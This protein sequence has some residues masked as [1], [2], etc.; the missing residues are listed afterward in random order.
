MNK[1]RRRPMPPH[2][3]ASSRIPRSGFTLIEM[4]I[5]V[6]LVLLMM[7]L[8]AE[9]FGL[10]SESM[11]LQQAIADGDQQV[12]SFTTVFRSDIQKRTFQTLVP[13]DNSEDPELAGVPFSDRQGYLYI[14]LNDPDNSTD[15]VLQFTVRSTIVDEN[16]D[17]T[18]YFG[19]ASGLV[20]RTPNVGSTSDSVQANPQQPEHDDGDLSNNFT[21]SSSAAEIA[22]FMRGGRLYRRVVLVREPLNA[23]GT[24]SGQPRLTWDTDGSVPFATPHEFLRHNP[25]PNTA[26]VIQTNNTGEYLKY[27]PTAGA[28]NSDDYWLDF[29]HGAYQAIA[30]T[31]PLSGT[32]SID[33]AQ[34]VDVSLLDNAQ[35]G[36]G[37][38]ALGLKLTP[39]FKT[40]PMGILPPTF[41][42]VPGCV[43]FGFDQTTGI[44]REF[45]HADPSTAGFSFLGRYTLE[46]MSHV[47][48][49]FPQN[50]A[51]DSSGTVIGNPMSYAN[52]PAAV[53]AGLFPDGVVDEFSGGS[54]RGQDLLLSNVHEF[55]I[56]IWDDSIGAF[57]SLGHQQSWSED[58]NNNGTLDPGEDLNGNNSIDTFPGD[59]HRFRNNQLVAGLVDV[60][61]SSAAWSVGQF[62]RWAGRS[63]DTWHRYSD[64]DGDFTTTADRVPPPYRAMTF[65][66]PG[67]PKGPYVSRGAWQTSTGGSPTTYASGDIVFPTGTSNSNFVAS[68]PRDYSFYY[69]C[70]DGGTSLLTEDV[71]GNNML[72]TEDANGNGVLDGDSTPGNGLFTEDV[73]DNGALDF[74]D[75]NGNFLIDTGEPVWPA[76]N[77][78][79]VE[80]SVP[81]NIEPR[82]VARRN[83][84][85][86]RAIR[87]RVRFFHESSGRM[88]QVSLVHS[89]VD[90]DRF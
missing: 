46:E 29:D 81:G 11:T 53:D 37:T 22:Y 52:F 27:D 67:S 90:E 83:V 75:T 89:L 41:Y 32:F 50:P 17:D 86:L 63:F 31:P 47:R 56:D 71:N 7:V 58:R 76:I 6:A 12:R 13:F 23:S 65:Y 54:R 2:N 74:E 1:R 33:G 68:T 78:A 34:L 39:T 49:N 88:R 35:N 24:N 30:E 80:R 36:G 57:T 25:N 38:Q 87:I 77:R 55:E 73:N 21:A 10:A 9:I 14:Q 5:S 60:P 40:D 28:L 66:P 61:G 8:F 82:W 84:K 45:S 51:I 18:E 62:S 3:L 26:P 43:R 44:S 72:D 64:L 42:G 4:L 20:Q 85:P 79:F 16:S 70:I 19:K 59:Y 48:F 69:V 15:N